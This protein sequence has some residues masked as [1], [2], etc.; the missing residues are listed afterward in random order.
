MTAPKYSVLA[1]VDTEQNYVEDENVEELEGMIKT[2]KSLWGLSSKSRKGRRGGR[3]EGTGVSSLKRL[4]CFGGP[5]VVTHGR[6]RMVVTIWDRGGSRRCVCR[7]G[8]PVVLMCGANPELSRSRICCLWSAR[9]VDTPCESIETFLVV[10]DPM[11]VSAA[12]C[13]H[14]RPCAFVA[15]F[16][17]P[18]RFFRNF[19]CFLCTFFTLFSSHS[20]LHTFFFLVV[21]CF[22]LYSLPSP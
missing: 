12:C 2:N 5:C 10:P 19:F 6:W 16:S 1:T 18:P 9:F 20:C 4:V 17:F 14:T 21:L 3:E 11:H 22:L 15:P 13:A 8:Q 7:G